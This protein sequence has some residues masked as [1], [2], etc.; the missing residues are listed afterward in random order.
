MKLVKILLLIF[1]SIALNQSIIASEI[2]TDSPDGGPLLAAPAIAIG[3]LELLYISVGIA[4]S[5]GV[6]SLSQS[7]SYK[8][9]I[10]AMID[11]I[12]DATEATWIV[13]K[14]EV[15]ELYNSITNSI[16]TM[17]AHS[18]CID[19]QFTYAKSISKEKTDSKTREIDDTSK[20]R[21]CNSSPECCKNFTEKFF[22]KKSFFNKIN[23]YSY[24][25]FKDVKL[26][27]IACCLEW[28]TMHGTW[29]VFDHTGSWI[30]ERN[31]QENDDPC[32]PNMQNKFNNASTHKSR[33]CFRK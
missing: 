17:Q 2:N 24:K 12:K 13:M 28:D 29:E 16:S 3:S 7:D 5:I 19:D 9:S 22:N 33:H 31:C 10:N 25:L 23:Q 15:L 6:I 4:A 30:G 11:K 20:S 8:T 32:K 1:I 27:K 14:S 21:G 18:Q 26:K